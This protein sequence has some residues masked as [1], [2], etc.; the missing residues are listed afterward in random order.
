MTENIEKDFEI[1]NYTTFKIGGKIDEVFFP[2]TVDEFVHFFAKIPE[3][4]YWA[5][6][7]I[8]WFRLSDMAEQ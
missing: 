2:S 3:Y 1:K 4:R 8:L 5:I 7:Q 6:C